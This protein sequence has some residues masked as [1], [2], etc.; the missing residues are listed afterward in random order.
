MTI[1][2][3]KVLYQDLPFKGLDHFKS[4]R[5][6]SRQRFERIAKLV[7]VK[8]KTILDLGTAEGS[9]ALGLMEKGAKRILAVDDNKKSVEIAKEAAKFLGYK[10]D[11]QVASITLDWVRSLPYY[12]VIIWLSQWQWLVKQKGLKYGKQL[13][14]EVSKKADV[15]VFESAASDGGGKIKKATQGDI[16]KW[17]FENTVYEDIALYTNEGI[18]KGGQRYLFTCSKPFIKEVTKSYKGG[19]KVIVERVA[20]DKIKKT[21]LNGVEYLKEREVK[22]LRRLAKYKHYPKLLEEGDNYIIET[23]C[24][25]RS[26]LRNSQE[27]KSQVEEIVQELKQE[28]ITHQDLY[29]KNM[30][31][32]NDVL[33]V[34]DFSRAV[35]D[36]EVSKTHWQPNSVNGAPYSDERAMLE[37]IKDSRQV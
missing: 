8:N 15:L 7:D 33:Y 35:F 25:R 32:L 17:V 27:M 11:F 37:T 13:L 26:R 3:T 2:T 28:K 14:F 4:R 10:V 23:Y 31:V 36:D 34:I 30:L 16:M 29:L 9:I 12:E 24:G 20:T 21:W 5:H 19:Q 22:A 1:Q 6:D 18:W